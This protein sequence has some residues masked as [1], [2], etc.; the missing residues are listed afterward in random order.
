MLPKSF[1]RGRRRGSPGELTTGPMVAEIVVGTAPVM[2]LGG[3]R[4]WAPL[5][6]GRQRG[7]SAV[8]AT[9]KRAGFK[10]V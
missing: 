7:G 4:R 9:S 2:G 8:G 10:V 3:G 6:L 5:E 1:Q